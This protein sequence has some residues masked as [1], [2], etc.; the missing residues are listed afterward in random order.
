MGS[1]G[2][3]SL[4]QDEVKNQEKWYIDS[5]CSY[6]MTGKRSNMS[7]L[8]A[9]QGENILFGDKSKGKVKGIGHVNFINNIKV[10]N[11]HL[12][13]NL[14]YNLISVSQLCDQGNNEVKFTSKEC[15]ISD[16]SGRTMLKG[17]RVNEVYVIDTRFVP[18]EKLCLS[19]IEEQSDL[20]HQRLGHASSKLIHKLHQKELVRG[21]PKVNGNSRELCS[22][23]AKGKQV[24]SSFKSKN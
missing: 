1:K 15:T 6:H 3:I 22:D 4:L 20:G 17:N 24:R 18:K 11:V 10:S 16:A 21:L 8:Q 13:D 23:C 2:L 14:G 7:S 5:G 12:V 9:Y 19:S